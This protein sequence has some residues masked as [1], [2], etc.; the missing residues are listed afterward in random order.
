M[1]MISDPI[2]YSLCLILVAIILFGIYLMSKVKTARLGN[3][4]SAFATFIAVILTII[5]YNVFSNN[6]VV[7]IIIVTLL[8]GSLIGAFLSI[9]LNDSNA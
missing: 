7:I 6:Q 5:H 4:L 1:K 3:M 8:I 9:K 2:Y